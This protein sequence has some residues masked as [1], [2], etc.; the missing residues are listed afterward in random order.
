MENYM[1]IKDEQFKEMKI[2]I[3]LLKIWFY[4]IFKA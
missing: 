2:L 3:K 4:D 1:C